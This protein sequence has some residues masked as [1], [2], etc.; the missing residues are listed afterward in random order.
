[1]KLH[2]EIHGRG[3]LAE[4]KGRRK[5]GAHGVVEHCGQKSALYVSGRI[6]EDLHSFESGLDGASLAV[7]LDKTQ[8]KRLGACRWRQAPVGALGHLQQA[9]ELCM[10]GQRTLP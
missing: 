9:F 7:D 5:R 4:I 6:E 3:E 8:A 2:I 1:M 10:G